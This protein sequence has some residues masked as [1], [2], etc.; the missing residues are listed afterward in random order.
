MPVKFANDQTDL[1]RSF[2]VS[3]GVV[4]HNEAST[5]GILKIMEYQHKYVPSND[6]AMVRTFAV[7]DLL[8]VERSQNAQE[9][10]IDHPKPTERL[11]GLIPGLAD[12]H[13]YGNFLEVRAILYITIM[14]TKF[15]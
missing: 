9:D 10:M 4:N 5:D 1:I 3:L 15:S 2:Q 13:T 11:E 12:F 14:L 7:G 8:T 6:H